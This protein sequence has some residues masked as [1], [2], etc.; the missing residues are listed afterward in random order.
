M[1]NTFVILFSFLS[2]FIYGQKWEVVSEDYIVDISGNENTLYS[3]GY[4]SNNGNVDYFFG[5]SIDGGNTWE[6]RIINQYINVDGDPISVGFFNANEGIIGIK[7][8]NTKEYL[9]TSDGGL[10]WESFIPLVNGILYQPYEIIILNQSTAIIIAF[11]S[12]NY[13]ITYDKGAT[14]S[15]EC[16]FS[17][18]WA[19]NLETINNS[20]F[21]NYDLNGIYKTTDSGSNWSVSLDNRDISAFSMESAE[22]GYAI[23]PRDS[24]DSNGNTFTLPFLHKTA[25]SWASS[26]AIPLMLLKDKHVAA[27][28]FVNSQEFYFFN[29]ENI[30]YSLDGGHTLELLQTINF[31]A[32]RIKKIQNNIYATGRGLVQYNPDGVA[33]TISEN[34]E[35]EKESVIYPNPITK[36]QVNLNTDKYTSYTLYD[37]SGRYIKSGPIVNRTID[38]KSFGKQFYFLSLKDSNDNPIKTFKIVIN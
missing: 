23:I 32:F 33:T 19:P 3:V 25:D 7:G 38:L 29:N 16:Q 8:S 4:Q 12:G 10:T 27:F 37:L 1:K 34:E 28:T 36:N 24:I 35:Q 31:D 14:W 30:Y 2:I 13:I 26:E 9:R 17:T 5:V 21:F 22:K 20:V 11:Q 15:C 6:K 18:S